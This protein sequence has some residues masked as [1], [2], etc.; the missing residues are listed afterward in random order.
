MVSNLGVD[1]LEEYS[2]SYKL[3]SYW[4]FQSQISFKKSVFQ[5]LEYALFFPYK[6]NTLRYSGIL[7]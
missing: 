1:D 7:F 2:Q 4:I 5:F 6:W 3:N